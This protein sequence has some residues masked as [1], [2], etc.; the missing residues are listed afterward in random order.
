MLVP[1]IQTDVSIIHVQKADHL[2]T[3]RIRG[4]PFADVEQIKA[5]KHVIVTCEELVDNGELRENSDQNKIPPFCVDAVV[6]V[7]F[8]AYPTACFGYY[9]YDPVYLKQYANYASDDDA[10]G[11][12]LDQFIFQVR[13]HNEFLNIAAA[14][15]LEDIKAHPRTGY[16]T[17][18]NRT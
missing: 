17:N 1:A 11:S 3:S 16:A 14:D 2:G 6:H 12:Y 8:G 10:Y 18:L 5:S 13:T 15:H 9:D 4:L 7:P